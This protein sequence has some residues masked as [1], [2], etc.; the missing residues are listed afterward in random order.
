[1]AK[2]SIASTFLNMLFVFIEY[3]A[4]CYISLLQVILIIITENKSFV[5]DTDKLEIYASHVWKLKRPKRS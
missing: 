3:I 4:V 5:M 2:F 1:M